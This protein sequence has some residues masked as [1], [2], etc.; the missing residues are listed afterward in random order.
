M[1]DIQ[2]LLTALADPTRRSLFERLTSRGPASAS[3]LAG[4]MPISRQAIAKHISTLEAA[5]LVGREES[6]REIR[7]RADPS[8]LSALES[9]SDLVN[10]QWR[11]RLETLS[12]LD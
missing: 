1:S 12:D 2:P 7:F 4:E 9:W 3:Q 11:R 10:D 5:G 6:G 8:G